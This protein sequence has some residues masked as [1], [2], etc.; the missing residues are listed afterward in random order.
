MII[1]PIRSGGIVP[2]EIKEKLIDYIDGYCVCQYCKGNLN[3]I[4]KPNLKKLINEDLP[5]LVNSDYARL[6]HGAREGFFTVFYA[7]KK[8]LNYE[9]V[10]LDANS[11]YSM[12]LAA[13][14]AG[15]K[16]FKTKRLTENREIV[17]E[18][19]E[20]TIKNA[21]KRYSKGIVC[22][23][24]PDGNYGNLPKLEKII[25]ISKS[26]GLPILVN[27]AYCVGRMPFKMKNIDFLVASAHKSMACSGPLGVLFFNENFYK[28]I[29]KRYN[30]KEIYFLGCTVRGLPAVNLLFVIDYLKERIK[31]WNKKVD[32][33]NKFIN[34][35]EKLGFKLIGQKPHKHDLLFFETPVLYEIA[36]KTNRYFL[37][38]ELK[39]RGIFGIKP[40][41]TKHIKLSTYLLSENEVELLAKVFEEIIEKYK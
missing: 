25:D 39:K 34:L 38:R 27:G 9:F 5:S 13:E 4:T 18:E 14:L 29:C 21:L 3:E 37:Y 11:H 40:G 26:Y 10:I 12:E 30:N 36:Q 33:A 24:Y 16:I 28:V 35:V 6:T 8:E 7:L 20:E 19:Y 2:D 31:Q 32:I 22:V 23:T 15:L 1:D 41:I 17:E